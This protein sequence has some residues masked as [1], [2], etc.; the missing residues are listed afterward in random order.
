MNEQEISNVVIFIKYNVKAE[1]FQE[2]IQ[3]TFRKY[4]YQNTWYQLGI[5][6]FWCVNFNFLHP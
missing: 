1:N 3:E 5:D 6:V 4:W 2:S